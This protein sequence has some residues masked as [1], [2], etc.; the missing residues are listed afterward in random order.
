[1]RAIGYQNPLALEDSAAL[2]DIELPQ[3]A[4]K[5]RDLLIEV[6]AVSVNPVDTK[7]RAGTKPE[8]GGWKVLGWDA[9]GTVAAIG[10][11][12]TLFRPGDDVFY[13]GALN[14]PGT[15]AEFHLVDQRIVGN[16]P[17]SLGWSETAALPLTA[18]TAWEALFDRLDIRRPVP[19]GA[20]RPDHRRCGR[21]WLD[22]RSVGTATDRS[23]VIATAARPETQTWVRDLGAHT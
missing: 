10:P 17:V 13:A 9:A 11:D 5:A 4:P 16:K 20:V 15:N 21:R 12:V 2:V 14:R 1:M 18:I 22:R 8:A 19:G 6:R 7:V 3:P 23:H